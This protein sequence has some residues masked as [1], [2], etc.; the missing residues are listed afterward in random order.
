MLND[1][2]EYLLNLYYLYRKSKTELRAL[3]NIV[4]ELDGLV[5]LADNFINDDGVATIRACGTRWIG[6]PIKAF[7]RAINKFGIYLADL[8][9]GGEKAKIKVETFSCISRC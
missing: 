5:D 8:E 4:D 9:K 1:I 3:E 7:Q 6:H 2:R